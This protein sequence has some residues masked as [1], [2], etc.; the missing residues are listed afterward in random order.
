MSRTNACLISW[1][2]CI[3]DYFIYLFILNKQMIILLFNINVDFY[4]WVTFQCKY[5]N[6][7]III[8]F[9]A[10]SSSM[11]FVFAVSAKLLFAKCC[12]TSFTIKC[13]SLLCGNFNQFC[14]FYV[15]FQKPVRGFHQGLQTRENW[16]KHETA[17][18][19]LLPFLSVKYANEEAKLVENV[20]LKS[21][22]YENKWAYGIF[23]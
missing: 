10:G 11:R 17:C 1:F 14:F 5:C 4:R 15:L 2:V 21:T 19:L 16:P 18:W 8:F 6:I 7:I 22:H 12:T 3:L 20:V 13:N 9:F 23:Q